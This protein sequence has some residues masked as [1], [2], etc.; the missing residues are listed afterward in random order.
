MYSH[1]GVGCD[2]V[3]FAIFEVLA[4]VLQS[5]GMLGAREVCVGF[6][7]DKGGSET[8]CVPSVPFLS[9]VIII[10][11]VLLAHLRLYA[12]IIRRTSGRSLETFRSSRETDRK[13]LSCFDI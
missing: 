11:S 9:H 6:V 2:D 3:Y 13:L 1:K 4:A 5:S 12:G 7:V 10:A 8:G